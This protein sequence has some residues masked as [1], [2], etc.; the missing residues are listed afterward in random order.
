MVDRVSNAEGRVLDLEDKVHELQG[1]VACLSTSNCL[2]IDRV[3][4][5][6]NHARRCNLHFVGFPE[7]VKDSLPET[8]IEQKS[9]LLFCC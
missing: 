1:T 3:E 2:M 6:V 8:F 7:G 4:D 9:L 5:A